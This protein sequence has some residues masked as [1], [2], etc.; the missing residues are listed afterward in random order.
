MEHIYQADSDDLI[1]NGQISIKMKIQ[2]RTITFITY[3]CFILKN[4]E[5]DQLKQPVI[6]QN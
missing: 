4:L 5:M 2:L 1:E 3:G 6:S